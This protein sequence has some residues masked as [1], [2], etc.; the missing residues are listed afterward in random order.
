MKIEDALKLL[1]F[2]RLPD[3]KELK[4]LYRALVKRYHPD[5]SGDP[6]AKDLMARINQA[7]L[8]LMHALT[9]KKKV[10]RQETFIISAQTLASLIKQLDE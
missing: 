7:Y 2:D 5:I 1:G 10:K 9:E 6:D 8:V 3:E 4:Q